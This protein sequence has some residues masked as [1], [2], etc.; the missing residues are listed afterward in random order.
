MENFY[1]IKSKYIFYKTSRYIYRGI[2]IREW[3]SLLYTIKIYIKTQH[4]LFPINL[5]GVKT[6]EINV[7][8]IDRSIHRNIDKYNKHKQWDR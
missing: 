3:I 8:N 4:N 5:R 1:Y 6:F 2:R 7:T